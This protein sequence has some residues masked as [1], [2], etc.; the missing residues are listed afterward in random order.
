M[1]VRAMQSLVKNELI[2]GV[3]GLDPGRGSQG[4]NFCG[5]YRQFQFS[6]Y[7]DI[8]ERSQW[9]KS[10]VP[11]WICVK[12]EGFFSNP[13]KYTVDSEEHTIMDRLVLNS[14]KILHNLGGEEMSTFA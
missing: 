2:P 14:R 5:R 6:L 3:S 8:R 11:C 7:S 12:D 4:F 9:H 10:F 13:L 1:D